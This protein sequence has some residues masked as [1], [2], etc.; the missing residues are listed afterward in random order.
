MWAIITVLQGHKVSSI[1]HDKGLEFAM[2]EL[3]NELMECESYF[4]KPCRSWEKV[5]V[6]NYNGLVRQCLQKDMT[7]R[8]L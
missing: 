8:P 1:T 5:G 3:V 4:C 2:H 6:E 7:S